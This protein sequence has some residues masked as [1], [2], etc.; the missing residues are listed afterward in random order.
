MGFDVR[1]RRA[2][3]CMSHLTAMMRDLVALQEL[4]GPLQVE[5]LPE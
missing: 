3:V 1:A 4:H 2:V 5:G